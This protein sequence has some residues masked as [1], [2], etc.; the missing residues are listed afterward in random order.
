MPEEWCSGDVDVGSLAG[1]L[2][3]LGAEALAE[4]LRF[5][6][7]RG[8]AALARSQVCTQRAACRTGKGLQVHHARGMYCSGEL[9][10]CRCT[11]HHYG[12][13]RWDTVCLSG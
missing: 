11:M 2:L 5:K 10:A 3:A 13:R 8:S 12:E 1:S 4:Q 6:G 7:S 9:R